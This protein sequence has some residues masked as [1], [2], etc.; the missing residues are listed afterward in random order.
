MPSKPRDR[1]KDD[2]RIRIGR[3]SQDLPAS[4]NKRKRVEDGESPTKRRKRDDVRRKHQP[5]YFGVGISSG[6][7]EDKVTF[8]VK[9]ESNQIAAAQYVEWKIAN[10]NTDELKRLALTRWERSERTRIRESN[11]K[12]SLY[13]YCL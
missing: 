9:D 11:Q 8:D 5:A 10:D 7:G 4:K 12:I 6:K 2:T 3:W 1:E 13:A